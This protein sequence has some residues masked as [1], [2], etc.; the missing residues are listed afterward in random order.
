[1]LLSACVY[2]SESEYMFTWVFIVLK[3]T[4]DGPL[5]LYFMSLLYPSV[6]ELVSF[7]LALL[8]W[9]LS[10]F[11]FMSLLCFPPIPALV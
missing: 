1:M 7:M 4:F 6:I 5:V 2:V 10:L 8:T 3:V 9:R 11:T